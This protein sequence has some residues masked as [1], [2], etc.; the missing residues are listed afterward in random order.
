MNP[1]RPLTLA[2]AATALA[3]LG[4]MAGTAVAP[5]PIPSAA[6]GRQEQNFASRGL[7][8]ADATHW[9]WSNTVPGVGGRPYIKRLAVSNDGGAHFDDLVNPDADAS[10]DWAPSA[11]VTTVGTYAGYVSDVYAF[12]TPTNGCNLNQH[13]GVDNC[14]D[15]PNR[16]GISL[17]R[18]GG[19]N[20]WYDDFTTH[21]SAN[22]PITDSSIIDL[23]IGFH[24]DYSTLRWSWANGVPSY[25]TSNVSPLADGEVRIKFTPKTVPVMNAGGCSQIPVS[26]CD[27][28]QADHEYLEPGIILSMDDTL[29]AALSGVLFGTSS[30][31]IG[32]LEAQVPSGQPPVLTYGVAAPHN[33]AGGTPRNGTFFALLPSS[34][35]TLFGTST[36]AFDSNIFSVARTGD[37]G[38]FSPSWTRWSAGANGTDGQLL[39]ISDISFSA[40]KFVVSRQASTG[41]GTPGG[42]ASQGG[43]TNPGGCT[44]SGGST[45]PKQISI[46]VGGKASFA[47]IAGRYGLDTKG[48]KLSAKVSTAKVC[49]VTGAA[50]KGIKPGSCK[51]TLTVKRTKGKPVNKGFAFTVTK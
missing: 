50:V 11:A 20:T 8:R 42:G 45:A 24:T 35:L 18:Y 12:I 17:M 47:Q 38:T 7:D 4:V 27:I 51:G 23:T 48:G 33:T 19:S 15:T 5:T 44:N 34:V 25:W 46:R 36:N 28:A 37:P 13:Q 22:P 31:F 1:F 49:K 26:T 32:S 39:T 41:G 9:G 40:P 14:Y 43:G 10:N 30:A 16:V 21:P 6:A 29:D 2:S 3:A